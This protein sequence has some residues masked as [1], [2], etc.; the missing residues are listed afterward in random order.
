[1]RIFFISLVSD[2]WESEE[3]NI[4]VRSADDPTNWPLK[5]GQ[6]LV[7]YHP[8]AKL[9]P[10]V[11]P[12]TEP[13]AVSQTSGYLKGL[14]PSDFGESRPPYFPFETLADFEQTELFVRCDRMDSEIN[15]QLGIWSRHAPDGGV[16]LKDA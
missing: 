6:M 14:H 7:I 15:Q 12:T 11:V 13:T 3:P 1:M 9:A 2:G 5:L 8:H 4:P 10:K 16:M